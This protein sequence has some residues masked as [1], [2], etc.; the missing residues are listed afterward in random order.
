VT[1]SLFEEMP[2]AHRSIYIHYIHRGNSIDASNYTPR[3]RSS[4]RGNLSA[5]HA[6]STAWPG[7]T[8]AQKDS[9]L[10]LVPAT[11]V[12]PSLAD[13]VRRRSAS[14]SCGRGRLPSE[15]A[16]LK[17]GSV[18]GGRLKS[19]PT[20]KF[21]SFLNPNGAQNQCQ[22]IRRTN[23]LAKVAAEL[24]RHALSSDEKLRRRGF[25]FVR[26]F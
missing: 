19:F 6:D 24:C 1:R 8:H 11:Q 22:E 4:L 7:G 23:E 25:S 3:H 17:A 14:C 21:A 18:S 2:G 15:A 13:Q 16:K 20:T 9:M 5:K 12:S 26:W 10:S